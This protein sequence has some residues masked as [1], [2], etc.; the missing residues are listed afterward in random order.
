MVPQMIF[1]WNIFQLSIKSIRPPLDLNP[2]QDEAFLVP[3]WENSKEHQV[4]KVD[5]EVQKQPI[6]KQQ[7]ATLLLPRKWHGWV[8]EIIRVKSD[9]RQFTFF[10]IL[11]VIY[12]TPYTQ[13]WLKVRKKCKTEKSTL[14]FCE[15]YKLL[16]LCFLL[17]QLLAVINVS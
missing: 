14:H 11:N 9:P 7:E 5:G 3:K 2:K 1:K 4:C 15:K 8:H 10:S 6:R 12:I 16:F 17:L 13:K